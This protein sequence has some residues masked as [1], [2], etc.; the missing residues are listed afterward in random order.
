[1][2]IPNFGLWTRAVVVESIDKK[3]GIRR[4]LTAAGELPAKLGLT[5]QKPLQGAY[6]RDPQA[7]EKWQ[8]ETYPAIVK[9]ANAEGAEIYCWDDSGC[10]ADTV[11][12]YVAS[13]P[14]CD[15][16]DNLA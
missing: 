5:P 6:R 13:P 16:I 14:N 1:L 9:R 15:G 4:G 11:G 7:I 10:R 12:E 3:F 2:I 8:R